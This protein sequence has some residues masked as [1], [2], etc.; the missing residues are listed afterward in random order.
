M[1]LDKVVPINEVYCC[2]QGEGQLCG[3]PHILIRFS[4][5]RLR[6]QFAN[7]VCDTW[8]SSWSPEK[9]KF[10]LRDIE[11]V[12]QDNP[13]IKHVMISGGGPTL[14]KKYLLP[15]M[16]LCKG[17]D[18][19][20]TL[21]TEGSEFIPDLPIDLLSLSPKL[22]SSIPIIDSFI[23]E[24]NRKVTQRDINQHEKWRTQYSAME[25]LLAISKDYQLKPVVSNQI[26]LAEVRTIQKRLNIPNEKVW[27]MLPGVTNDQLKDGRKWLEQLCIEHGYNYCERLHIII[28][29]DDR[30]V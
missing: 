25:K 17:Y 19:N 5:C 30:G 11:A 14:Q 26:D 18:K 15:V 23:P 8:Y 24:L 12:L 2:V 7:S 27:L 22:Q 29:G 13:Q 10:T 4:G 21:E 1:H 20:I 3:V 6:C 28:H 16:R 9:G